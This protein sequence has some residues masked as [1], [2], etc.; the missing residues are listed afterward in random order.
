MEAGVR[1]A[2]SKSDLSP[3]EATLPIITAGLADATRLLSTFPD[4]ERTAPTI[5]SRLADKQQ[6]QTECT[7]CLS[8][9]EDN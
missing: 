7:H 9:H 5:S 1:R 3:T 2:G 4:V 6:G 8:G